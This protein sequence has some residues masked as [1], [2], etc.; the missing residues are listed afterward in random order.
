MCTPTGLLEACLRLC[1]SRSLGNR[2]D[3][4]H[5]L[6][7]LFHGEPCANESQWGNLDHSFVITPM[8]G[9]EGEWESGTISMRD[10]LGKEQFFLPRGQ[11]FSM[12]LAYQSVN[13]KLTQAQIGQ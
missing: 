8:R 10:T 4:F 7:V 9:R 13:F 5:F 3:V 6:P 11:N 2:N 1:D 12:A